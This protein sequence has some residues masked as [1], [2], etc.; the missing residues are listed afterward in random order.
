MKRPPGTILVTHR[1][2][3]EMLQEVGSGLG[4]SKEE[5]DVA[6]P[7]FGEHARVHVALVIGDVG[8]AQVGPPNVTAWGV[9]PN[10]GGDLIELPAS[11]RGLAAGARCA[12]LAPYEA[13]GGTEKVWTPECPRRHG[14]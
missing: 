2:V 3:E 7:L 1:Y 8:V 11:R 12:M 13:L 14:S 4:G 9:F 6:G 10:G 5:A